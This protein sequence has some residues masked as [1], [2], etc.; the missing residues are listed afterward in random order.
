MASSAGHKW[1]RKGFGPSGTLS[2]QMSWTPPPQGNVE[3]GGGAEEVERIGGVQE[4]CGRGEG[5]GVGEHPFG[6]VAKSLYVC[7]VST[8]EYL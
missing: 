3:A 5:E 1:P 7:G 4:G 8:L 6:E 2:G